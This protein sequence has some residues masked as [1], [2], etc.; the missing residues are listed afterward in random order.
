MEEPSP[1]LNRPYDIGDPFVET[2]FDHERPLGQ[3]AT[4][5]STVAYWGEEIAGLDSHRGYDFLLP[6]GT[7]VL[8]AADGIVSLTSNTD[9]CLG[10]QIYID[11]ELAN[12][13]TYR[14]IYGHLDVLQGLVQRLDVV[15]AGQAIGYVSDKGNCT[16]YPALHFEVIR[17]NGTASGQ[18]TPVDPFG[19]T[20]SGTDPWE[21]NANGARSTN[22]WK[23]Q[24]APT[25]GV[26]LTFVQRPPNGPG[27]GP[28]PD[29]VVIS[30]WRYIGMNDS[31]NPNN[32]YV[33]I[34]I[35][36]DQFAG[37]A[38]DLTGMW[39]KD[40]AGDRFD[41]PDGLMLQSGDPIR[42]YVGSGT[43]SADVLYWGQSSG[44][45]DSSGDCVQLRFPGG[46]YYLFGNV[47]CH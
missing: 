4:G 2:L 41:F 29:P 43:A 3:D 44:I 18:A 26:G 10:N 32:E 14:T 7:E 45:F 16:V 36:P 46:G 38:Y 31:T 42:V 25:I 21:A 27:S 6:E 22:L 1:F 23:T 35:D 33:E 37:A 47:A 8:A 12:G 34:R 11:H 9:P 30:A 15:Q 13:L 24:Q 40:N 39:L 28:D 20:G 5:G 17:V 19:W